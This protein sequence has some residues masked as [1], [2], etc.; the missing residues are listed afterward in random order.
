MPPVGPRLMRTASS[1]SLISISEMPDSSSSSISFFTLRMSIGVSRENSCS[2]FG[3]ARGDGTQGE[4]I[5]QR[6]QAHDLAH[7][8][9]GKIRVPAEGF[10]RMHIGKVDFDER[11]A[12][13]QD[14]VAQRDAAVG[15]GSRVQD[16]EFHPLAR[17]ALHF[18][19]EF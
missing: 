8:D 11:Q 19:Y 3:E 1:P 13:A 2:A 17:R 9:V 14:G 15:E 10:P 16:H 4:F 6:A 7:G 18:V 5:T 12:D